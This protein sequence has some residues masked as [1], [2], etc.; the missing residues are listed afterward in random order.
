MYF[1]WPVVFIFQ[2]V[3]HLSDHNIREKNNIRLIF[4]PL[5][6]IFCWRF[7]GGKFHGVVSKFRGALLS[8][9]LW[10]YNFLM[11]HNVCLS[12][13]LSVFPILGECRLLLLILKNPSPP[14]MRNKQMRNKLD[15]QW[16]GGGGWVA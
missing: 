1:E 5:K 2:N 9:I 14:Q 11:N 7:L 12:V 16:E 13:C 15:R 3:L 4:G 8:L 10:K 6:I